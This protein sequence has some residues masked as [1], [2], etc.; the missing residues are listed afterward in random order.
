MVIWDSFDKVRCDGTYSQRQNV[1]FEPPFSGMPA[2]A[3]MAVAAWFTMKPSMAE[4]ALV[5]SLIG[6]LAGCA[7]SSS[8]QLPDQ[9]AKSTPVEGSSKTPYQ[10]NP[11]E[12][13]IAE[14]TW[15]L[16]RSARESHGCRSK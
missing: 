4:L 12:C 15:W 10:W 6:P 3:G 5:I 9:E 13:W 11:V 1:P 14:E 16:P 8:S 7:S 2:R